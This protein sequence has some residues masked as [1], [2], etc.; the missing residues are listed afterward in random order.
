MKSLRQKGYRLGIIA[1][2]NAGL[3]Q[4]L[5]NWGLRRYFDVIASSAE[6]GCAKP[7]REIFEKALELAHCAAQDSIMVGDR[8]D[9]D[10]IPA[11]KLG[12]KT[13]WIKK[14]FADYQEAALGEGIADYQIHTLT[15][16]DEFLQLL[17]KP[18]A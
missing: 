10:I 14:G 18:P 8:L 17:S 1:N 4:R 15:K 6:M 3:E 5:Q 9:N 12:M 2:Q 7:G 11:I 13:V 16:L